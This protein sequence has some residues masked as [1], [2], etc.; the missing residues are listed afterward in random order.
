MNWRDD[1]DILVA[2][3]EHSAHARVIRSALL[4]TPVFALCFGCWVY[5]GFDRVARGGDGGSTWFL[6]VVLTGLTALFAFPSIQALLDLRG[7]PREDEVLVVR[8]WSR[9]DAFVVKNHFLKL[10]SGQI[11]EGNALSIEGVEE[12]G[13]ALVRYYPHSAILIWAQRAE[14]RTSPLS[15]ESS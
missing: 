3:Q 10:E 7:G 8:R 5:F 2:E 12:G 1:P 13:R 11:L 14:P 9:R 6:M 4:W 15:E